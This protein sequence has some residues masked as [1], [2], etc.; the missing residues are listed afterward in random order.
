MEKHFPKTWAIVKG[1]DLVVDPK[2]DIVDGPF[3]SNL[4]ASEYIDAGVPIVRIQNVKR[5]NFVDKNIKF[6]SKAKYQE[7]QRHSFINGDILIT[8]LGD[9]LG[10]ACEVPKKYKYGIII[11]DLIRLRP[12][13]KICS[14][15]FLI[16][17]LNSEIVIKQIEKHVKGTTRPRINLDVVRGLT[18]P[19]P[20][21]AEQKVI[22]DKL[23]IL[24]AK[25]EATKV[26]LERILNIQKNIRQSILSSAISGK[27]TEEWRRENDISKEGW[28]ST[29]L[30]ALAEVATGKTPKRAN[31][32][33]WEGGTIPWLTSAATG[34]IFTSKAE[35]FVTELAV[36]ECT[37]KIF[38]I[39]TLLL[40]MYGE[41]KT[42]G[43]VTEIQL[44]ATCNQA[45]AAI[46]VDE[47]KISKEF[48]KICLLE[49]YEETRKAAAGGAQP[50]L[51]LNK[52]REIHIELPSKSEQYAIVRC[53]EE[54]LIFADSIERMTNAALERVNNLTQSILTKAFRGDLTAD[55]REN[56]PEL[57]SNE[58][59]AEALLEKIKIEHAVIKKQSKL[60]RTTVKKKTGS[61]MSKQIIKVV[62][63]LKQARE[64]L[65][66][67]QLLAAAGYPL[68]SS[69]D[70]LEQFFLDIRNALTIERSIIKLERDDHSQ[71]WFT[72]APNSQK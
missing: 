53:V 13:P 64:P 67:Q 8:K 57:I 66:G 48:L 39:G 43:Q 70:E 49:N 46:L 17:L 27:L 22:A 59:S 3:G 52:V 2:S 45:C 12:N 25:V 44:E 47:R 21:L 18:L 26:R 15:S 23:D 31:S 37:L 56:N 38:P 33:Y 68:D 32:E 60:K 40:A 10:L 58:N 4:K 54:L 29:N 55:W 65:S 14:K 5:F 71:D 35:Q 11:A 72:L 69:T 50:N 19:L 20:P 16:C 6:V 34:S 61:H 9:P 30:G 1:S 42:R 24:L 36:K 62:E 51:N 41:G 63:A 28:L 7:L